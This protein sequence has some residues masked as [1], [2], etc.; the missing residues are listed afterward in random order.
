[1]HYRSWIVRAKGSPRNAYF[2]FAGGV[3]PRDPRGIPPDILLELPLTPPV[4]P[5]GSEPLEVRVK[6]AISSGQPGLSLIIDGETRRTE[7]R[8][9]ALAFDER[10]RVGATAPH[11]LLSA[12]DAR[13]HQSSV[14]IPILRRA[15]AKPRVRAAGNMYALLVGVSRFGP[16]KA[17]AG[18]L[19]PLAGPAAAAQGLATR[20][21]AAGFPRDNIRLLTDEDATVDQIRAALTDFVAKAGPRDLVLVFLSTRAL[22]DPERPDVFHLAGYGAQ[23][24]QLQSTALPLDELERLLNQNLRS[25]QAL[26]VFDIANTAAVNFLDQRALQL[27]QDQEGRAVLV[28]GLAGNAADTQLFSGALVEALGP[29]ADL[30]GNRFLTAEEMLCYVTETVKRA[31]QGQ[32]TPRFRISAAGTPPALTLP[33]ARVERKP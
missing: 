2:I 25:G 20:L 16:L 1:V 29:K 10:V 31:S 26:V 23:E 33:E 21:G 32:Q 27:F 30:D 17:P 14:T 19:P 12:L 3:S 22:P 8:K 7:E 11:V 24:G 9:T 28:S 4:A 13:G 18:T 5:G 6:G 15:A